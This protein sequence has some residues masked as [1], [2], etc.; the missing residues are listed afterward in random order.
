MNGHPG[1]QS[2]SSAESLP[3]PF[4]PPCHTPVLPF[5]SHGWLSTAPCARQ[6]DDVYLGV[7]KRR[8]NT[9]NPSANV[10]GHKGI[11]VDRSTD[12]LVSN[13]RIN[14]TFYHDISVSW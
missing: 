7:T 2:C 1:I 13:F 11:V 6:V 4:Y 10:D 5:F 12:I 8:A 3:P 9:A 14:A